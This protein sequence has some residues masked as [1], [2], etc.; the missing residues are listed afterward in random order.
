MWR[1][2]PKS[3]LHYRNWNHEWAVFDVGS[4][5]TH[6]MD[7]IAAVALMHCESGWVRLSEI[8]VGVAR[9]LELPAATQLS[10]SLLPLLDQFTALGLLEHRPE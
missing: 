4:G 5:Q 8:A 7:T 9:E 6:E 3:Q 2:N 1:I 10:D